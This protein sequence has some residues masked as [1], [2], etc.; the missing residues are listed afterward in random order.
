M[1]ERLIKR[2]DEQTRLKIK[3]SQL[4]N[5]LEN[6][7]LGEN[8]MTPTQIRAAEICLRKTLPD[9]TSTQISGHIEQT[10]THIAVSEVDSRITDLL[11]SR[12][13]R[14]MQETRT[15]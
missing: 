5:R 13:D 4:L 14:D 3:T 10:L 9:L 15:H 7:A 2:H 1:A 12:E 8:D 6:H 11:G